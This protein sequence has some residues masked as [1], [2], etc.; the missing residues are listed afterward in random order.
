M[1]GEWIAWDGGKQ[2]VSNKT[3][4]EV[5]FRGGAIDEDLASHWYWQHDAD[6]SDIVAYRVVMA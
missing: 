3:L 1:R 4:V 6:E 5:E 2:P